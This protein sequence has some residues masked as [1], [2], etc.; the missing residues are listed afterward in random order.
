MTSLKKEIRGISFL[1]EVPGKVVTDIG[2]F[3]KTKLEVVDKFLQYC[4]ILRWGNIY[5]ATKKSQL[6]LFVNLAQR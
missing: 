4:M 6:G 2:I 3:D 5:F 1:I